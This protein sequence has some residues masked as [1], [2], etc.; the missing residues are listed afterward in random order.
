[1]MIFLRLTAYVAL[2]FKQAKQFIYV[3][4]SIIEQALEWLSNNQGSNGSFVETGNI[5]YDDLQ[6]RNGNSLALTAFTL[7]AF[8]ENQVYTIIIIY[9]IMTLINV[10]NNIRH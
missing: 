7:L 6:N 10:C 5:I 9:Q 2:A 1:M 4:D 3:D 8:M